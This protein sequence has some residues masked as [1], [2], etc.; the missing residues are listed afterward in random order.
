MVGRWGLA[1]G[2]PMCI[3]LVGSGF[4]TLLGGLTAGHPGFGLVER[5]RLDYAGAALRPLPVEARSATYPTYNHPVL[6]Q[7]RKVVLGYPGHLWT[8]GFDYG[9]TNDQLTAL[10]NG[11]ANW[12]EAAKALSVRNVL[13]GQDERTNYH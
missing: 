4:V 3:A 2:A 9:E 13:W 12:R 7:G 1:G 10:M 11:A 5:A 6:L 8:E